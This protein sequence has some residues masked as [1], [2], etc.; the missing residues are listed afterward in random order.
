MKGGTMKTALLSCVLALLC[1]LSGFGL[2]IPE[3]WTKMDPEFDITIDSQ[4]Q[5]PGFLIPWGEKDNTLGIV[6]IPDDTEA[7]NDITLVPIEPYDDGTKVE[8]TPTEELSRGGS[9]EA[10]A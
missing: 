8:M 9:T 5:D 4:E 2:V 3:E 1:F 7:E 10:I 6:P